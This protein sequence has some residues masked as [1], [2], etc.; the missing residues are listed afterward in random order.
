M[1]CECK[2]CVLGGCKDDAIE[3]MD[4]AENGQFHIALESRESNWC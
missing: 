1:L 2:T 4:E 3:K